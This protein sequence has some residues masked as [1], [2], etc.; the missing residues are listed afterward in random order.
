MSKTYRALEK[1]SGDGKADVPTPRVVSGAS[2][3]DRNEEGKDDLAFQKLAVSLT[4]SALAGGPI[5][6]LLV[7]G[8]RASVG[9]TTVTA[10]LAATLARGKK[11]RVLA[12]DA[13]MRGPALDRVFHARHPDGLTEVLTG[14]AT[15]ETAIQETTAPNLHVLTSGA[16]SIGP[17]ELLD[18][19]T[20]EALMRRLREKFNF[21][22]VDSAPVLDFPDACSLA[23]RVDGVLLVVGAE[24]TSIDDAQ[25][26]RRDL[27]RAGGR[28]LGVVLN[29]KRTYIPRTLQRLLNLGDAD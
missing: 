8:C 27:V 6:T 10:R 22:V 14:H 17:A 7:T 15:I 2:V 19:V 9:T 16:V 3:M 23:P 12:V 11:F 29:R 28:L 25:T 4:S 1:A 20:I 13:N 18:G 21:I 5:Q 26:A 24:E